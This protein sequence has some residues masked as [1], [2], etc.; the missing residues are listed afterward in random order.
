MTFRLKQNLGITSIGEFNV[1]NTSG[2]KK[3]TKRYVRSTQN[4]IHSGSLLAGMVGGA[5]LAIALITAT[6]QSRLSAKIQGL[7]ESTIKNSPTSTAKELL[8]V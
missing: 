7:S 5:V 1:N 2:V 3:T 6:S 8:L 4:Q